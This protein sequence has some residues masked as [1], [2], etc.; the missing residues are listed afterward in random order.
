MKW[1]YIGIPLFIFSIIFASLHVELPIGRSNVVLENNGVPVPFVYPVGI[2]EQPFPAELNVT[3]TPLN[4]TD[5]VVE[6]LVTATVWN[7]SSQNYTYIDFWVVNNTGMKLLYGYLLNNTYMYIIN[8]TQALPGVK[9]YAKALDKALMVKRLQSLDYDGNYTLV[10]INPYE[11]MANVSIIVEETWKETGRLLEPNV[12]SVSVIVVTAV[13]GLYITV[14]NPRWFNKKTM[15][16]RI[17][18]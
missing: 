12:V 2:P 7:S 3:L 15:R 14:K 1:R 17:R 6:A 5:Y 8:Q 10:L 4:K 9:A 13:L 11:E 16:R 18:K